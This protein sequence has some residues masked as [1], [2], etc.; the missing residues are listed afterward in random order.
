MIDSDR[1]LL[2]NRAR[3]ALLAAFPDAWAIYVYGSFARSE[4]WPDSD[5]DFA[6]LLPPGKRVEDILSVLGRLSERVGR[7]V[8]LVDMRRI[9][10]VLRREVLA[11]GR[12]LFVS[13]P[14]SVL[15]WEASAMSRYA[16][17]REEIKDILRDFERT[18][19]GYAP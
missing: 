10:D 8:D 13:R 12:T 7:D 6:V 16:R 15:A 14:D 4:E 17:H 18:G 11:T 19:I 1:E 2:F 3:E 9:G 5:I